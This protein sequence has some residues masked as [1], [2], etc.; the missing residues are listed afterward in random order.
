M[1]KNFQ[2]ENFGNNF[3]LGNLDN[4]IM[5][6]NNYLKQNNLSNINN[7]NITYEKLLMEKQYNNILSNDKTI[8]DNS[9]SLNM[10]EN[11][12][13]QKLGTLNNVM[14]NLYYNRN[15]IYQN[16]ILLKFN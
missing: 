9:K 14:N 15:L 16:P 3:L 8:H 4:I 2:G 7:N 1:E 6:Q 12:P 11:K 13:L 10:N 5:Y